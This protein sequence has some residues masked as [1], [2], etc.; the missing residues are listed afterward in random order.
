MVQNQLIPQLILVII[1][2][3]QLIT[4]T[5]IES[6][7]LGQAT[8]KRSQCGGTITADSNSL[9]FPGPG[10]SLLPGEA[11][12]WTIHLE[13]SRDFRFNFSQFNVTSE[14]GCRDAGIRLY[15]LSNLVPPDRIE[16]YT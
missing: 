13:T 15:A 8:N 5:A 4:C 11:C 1:L 7:S 3:Y 10:E 16:S 6:S 12:V 2:A 9:A 14:N